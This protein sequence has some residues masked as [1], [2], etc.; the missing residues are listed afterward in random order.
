MHR[1]D[2]ATAITVLKESREP[3]TFERPSPSRFPVRL[4]VFC[5]LAVLALIGLWASLL[6]LLPDAE[7]VDLPA[8]HPLFSA[9]YNLDPPPQIPSL[10]SWLRTGQNSEIGPTPVHYYG[11]FDKLHRLVV[12][13]SMNSDVSDSWERE[14]DNQAYFD[15]FGRDGYAMGVDVAVYAMTH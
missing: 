4:V 13:V 10:G 2:L 8:D 14:G 15:V 5:A 6:R 11:V 12:L 7:I 1:P 9:V 3:L